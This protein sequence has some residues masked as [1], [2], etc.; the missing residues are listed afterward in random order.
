[1]KEIGDHVNV[2]DVENVHGIL[3]HMLEKWLVKRQTMDAHLKDVYV[4]IILLSI[5]DFKNN[6]Y[7]LLIIQ[8]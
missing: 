7:L 3:V 1:M 5:I 2:V 4:D 8:L 6:K